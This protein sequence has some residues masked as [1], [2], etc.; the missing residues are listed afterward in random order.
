MRI[1]ITP[2]LDYPPFPSPPLLVYCVLLIYE[3]H[4]Y[5]AIYCPLFSGIHS[6]QP[7]HQNCFGFLHHSIWLCMNNAWSQ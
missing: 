2:N 4:C 7:L 3:V 6:I 1:M 5:V